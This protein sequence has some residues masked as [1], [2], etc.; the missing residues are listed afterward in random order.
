M[1]AFLVPIALLLSSATTPAIEPETDFR[2]PYQMTSESVGWPPQRFRGDRTATVVFID[3]AGVD[4]ACGK[5]RSG[6]IK[7]ACAH[8]LEDRITM[9]NPCTFPAD[10]DYARIAC[11]E[12]SHLSGWPG[13][14]GA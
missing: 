7:I 8:L 4:A 12:L 9:P 11:H 14:H 5:A 2:G 10:D 3:Q 1:K 13:Y 6:K